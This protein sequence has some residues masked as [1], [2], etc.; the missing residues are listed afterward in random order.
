MKVPR[1]SQ[2]GLVLFQAFLFYLLAVP[3]ASAQTVGSTIMKGSASSLG[4]TPV[5]LNFISYIAGFAVACVG[6]YKLK[7]HIDNPDRTPLSHGI[8]HLMGAGLLIS[9]P[10]AAGLLQRTFKLAT[11]SGSTKTA[12]AIALN[13]TGALSL[14]VMM[15]RFVQDIRTP[16]SFLIWALGVVL[17]F[18]FL[19]T[20]FMRMARGAAQD[21]ARGSLGS[22][23]LMRVVI[24]SILISTSATADVFTNTL[25][26]GSVMRFNGLDLG[27]TIAAATLDQANQAFAAILIFIQII[28]FIAFMRGF[29]MLRALADGNSSISTAAA[30]T[31]IFGGAVAIN[32]SSALNV[33]QNTFCGGK[34]GCA[35]GTFVS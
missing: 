26:G 5:L 27:G 11:A 28:G 9:L 30:F 12:S 35:I 21:G 1:L 19:I 8:W 3:F 2:T 10:M 23:T 24:G 6:L 34:A 13:T 33:L 22:G 20:A 29:L 18:F 17:G 4:S 15:I 32:I 14:D 25:F 7:S 31:H 16:M